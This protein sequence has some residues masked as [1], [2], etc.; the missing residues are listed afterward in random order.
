MSSLR[1]AL[2][3]SMEEAKDNDQKK[4]T[5]SSQNNSQTSN[6]NNNAKRKR[7]NS[8]ISAEELKGPKKPP[9]AEEGNLF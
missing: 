2:K 9:K 4:Q 7:S 5:V 1:L 3:L 6:Q 8:E